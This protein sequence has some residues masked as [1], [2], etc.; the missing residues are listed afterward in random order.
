M[1]NV[2]S[3]YQ[4]QYRDDRT[5]TARRLHVRF[6]APAPRTRRADFRHRALPR[7]HAPRTQTRR[8]GSDTQVIGE[9]RHRLRMLHGARSAYCRL[10]GEPASPYGSAP[11]LMHGML[12]ESLPLSRGPGNATPASLLPSDI[13]PRLRPLSSTGIT[14]RPR[15]LQY[16]EPLRHPAGPACPSRD[17]GWCV[18]TTDRASRVASIPLLHACRRQYPG[19]TGWCVH[20]S[21]PCRWQPSPYYRRVGFRITLFEACSAFTRVAARMFA[22]PPMAALFFGVLQTMSLPLGPLRLLVARATVAGRDSRPLRNNA[23]PRRR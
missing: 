17:S 13:A 15:R 23:F 8:G 16:Y 19:G 14:R 6:P 22:E 1:A 11:S 7:D 3:R 20:R 5:V 10:S 12:P 18:H 2:S 21:L 9:S 4:P